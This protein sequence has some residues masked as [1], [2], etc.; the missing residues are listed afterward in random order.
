MVAGWASEGL[1]RILKRK[2]K[3][4]GGL[5]DARTLRLSHLGKELRIRGSGCQ[6]EKRRLWYQ[7]HLAMDARALVLREEYF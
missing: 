4:S 5:G 3:T 2:K 7:N 6:E 1:I